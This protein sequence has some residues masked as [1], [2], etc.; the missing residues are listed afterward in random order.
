MKFVVVNKR[1]EILISFADRQFHPQPVWLFGSTPA[2]LFLLI[3]NLLLRADHPAKIQSLFAPAKQQGDVALEEELL[4]FLQQH[5]GDLFTIELGADPN[6]QP[7]YDFI[8]PAIIKS[9]CRF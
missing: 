8:E 4:I 1:A 6:F 9:Q 7:G 2:V 3:G 5:D